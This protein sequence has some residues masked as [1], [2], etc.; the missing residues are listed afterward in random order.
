MMNDLENTIGKQLPSAPQ[1]L[2]LIKKKTTRILKSA[3][4]MNSVMD[5]RSTFVVGTFGEILKANT[6]LQTL[7][8][9]SMFRLL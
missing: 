9:S 7:N 2:E 3:L 1:K 8:L 6:T 5:L 4:K